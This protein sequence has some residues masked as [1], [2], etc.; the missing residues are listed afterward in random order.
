[1][2][3]VNISIF[4]KEDF[5]KALKVMKPVFKSRFSLSKLVALANEGEPIG[6]FITPQG[7]TALAT[8]CSIT[9]N[10]TLLK[11]GVP[12]DSRFG[13]ILQIRNDEPLRFVELIHYAGSSLDRRDI[14]QGK[15]TSLSGHP[16]T[17]TVKYWQIT[18]KY[19]P[20]AAP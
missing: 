14:H 9:V 16:K 12:I 7:K 3:P 4:R 10:G 6:D 17:A 1:L 11:A 8:V 20:S 15:M 5:N 2:I 19:R 13:G 18:G